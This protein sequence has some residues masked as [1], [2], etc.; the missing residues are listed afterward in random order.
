MADNQL[1]IIYSLVFGAVLLGV[2]ALYWLVMR[3]RVENKIINR[4]LALS[5]ELSD[6]VKVLDALRRERGLGP[7]GGLR[8]PES[9]ETTI[10]QSG[11]QLTPARLVS[12]AMGLTALC[13]LPLVVLLGVG[14]LPL[15][16]AIP[17]AAVT[18]YILV[19]WARA[20]RIAKFSEQLPEALDI[21]VRS[22]RA[23]HPFRA[24]IGLV[25]R[26]LADPIGTE[27][28]ILL[29]EISFGLDQQVAIDHLRA[30]VGQEDLA[31][32]SIAVNI[33]THTGGNLAE[34]LHSLARLL[35]NRSKLQ[36]KVRALSSEGRLS[37]LFLSASPFILF[38][39]ISLVNPTY[40]GY[41]KGSPLVAPALII[42]FFLLALGN[43]F[44]YRMVNFR[45]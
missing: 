1:W 2:R 18:G 24:A 6:P 26:E 3:S 39:I 9:F 12:W 41:L 31:F 4:R 16:P 38:L 40:Y 23:G 28:G 10:M 11:L 44:I 13:Y 29:D 43:F 32:M 8:G 7:L 15:L 34:V 22:L 45:F 33:Q 37:G 17:A 20:R 14:F 25:A 19:R 27:F 36:L 21:I 42:G 35:R 5:N 30:R